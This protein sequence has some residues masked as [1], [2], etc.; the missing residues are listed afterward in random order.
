MKLQSQKKLLA[1]IVF[2][3]VFLSLFIFNPNNE[4]KAAE[5]STT[6]T[7][8]RYKSYWE[9]WNELWDGSYVYYENKTY[10]E[11]MAICQNE[12]SSK[13]YHTAKKLS[14]VK[15][16]WTPNIDTNSAT[17]KALGD[18]SCDFMKSPMVC[19]LSPVLSF[20]RIIFVGAATFFGWVIKTENTT[21][22]IT[23]GGAVWEIWKMVRDIFNT[24]F[25]LVLLFSAF[26]TIFQIDKYSYKKILLM[27]VIMALLVNFSYPIARF[28]IDLSNVAMYS[29]INL[30]FSNNPNATFFT[31]DFLTN[32]SLDKLFLTS[33]YKQSGVGYMLTSVVFLLLFAITLFAVAILLFVRLIVLAI[34]VIFSPIGFVGY[35]LPG[36]QGF[37]SQ[38]WD[39]LFKYAFFGPIMIL[40]L[41]IALRMMTAINS[42]GG[43]GAEANNVAPS[44]NYL[45]SLGLLII[46]IVILWLVMG[47]SQKMSIEGAAKAQSFAM[48]AGKKVSGYNWG[49]N[50]YDKYGA[51]RKKRKDILDQTAWSSRLGKYAG[52]KPG[53]WRDRAQGA[54][55]K[56]DKWYQGVPG[57]KAA[58]IRMSE[59]LKRDIA[60]KRKA[61][62]E[63]GVSEGELNTA[64]AKGSLAE[65]RAAALEMAEK[66]GFGSGDD[67]KKNYKLAVDALEGDKISQEIFNDKVKEKHVK[68][69]MDYEIGQ[70]IRTE[71]QAYAEYVDKMNAD[72]LSKQ[73][74]LLSDTNFINNYL[75]SRSN[76]DPKFI[77]EVA[78]KLSQADREAWIRENLIQNEGSNS[79]GRRAGFV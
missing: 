67:A 47:V 6:G 12:E 79:G 62:K 46:P 26:A 35:V 11:C 51:E 73:K 33:S 28:L 19:L 76:S 68:L 9:R 71:P 18:F 2:F 44:A 53:E 54:M 70:G 72:Q 21:L 75:R 30:N 50:V 17:D 40:G 64:L 45:G 7:C 20:A 5:K 24:A 74:G 3:L 48:K 16:T 27:L 58:Q 31:T 8:A 59:T 38:W 56:G 63:T 10:D 37:A 13:C 34:L 4:A 42:L 29:L 25:I 15:G 55:R 77:E 36:F 61:W 52:S 41:E 43:L 49:K 69:V 39:N 57:S 14:E 65:R 32:S 23:G 66:R 1:G 78:K 60:E 22:V